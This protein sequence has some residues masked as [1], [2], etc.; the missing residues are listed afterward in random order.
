MVFRLLD[1]FCGPPA[2]SSYA[3]PTDHSLH[4]CP[5]GKA[6]DVTVKA[7]E[8]TRWEEALDGDEPVK[9][10]GAESDLGKRGSI[11]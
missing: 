5:S 4:N 1:V 2:A 10:E 8:G 11:V 9:R 7:Q 3:W 6:T